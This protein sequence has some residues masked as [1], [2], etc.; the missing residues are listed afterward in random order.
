MKLFKKTKFNDNLQGK[1][2]G[3]LGLSPRCGTTTV[4][5]AIGNHLSDSGGKTVCIIEKNKHDDFRSLISELGG[6]AVDGTFTYHRVTYVCSGA[7]EANGLLDL[8]FDCTVFDLGSDFE[9]ALPTMCLCDYR[10][11][12]GSSAPW[13]R[14][15]YELLGRLAD[16]TD[17]MLS[18]RLFINLGNPGQSLIYKMPGP[19][20]FCFPFEPDPVY[21]GAEVTKLLEA[22][23]N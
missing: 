9:A 21:P 10:I 19:E 8:S 1:R 5:L 22:V 13:R 16:K 12:V 18:W 2:I 6:E 4:A 7:G 20:T 15:E 23:L 3:V 17:S 11:L 14:G